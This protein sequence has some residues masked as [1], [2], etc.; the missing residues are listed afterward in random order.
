MRPPLSAFVIFKK[1]SQ[2]N[3]YKAI[4][5]AQ[6]RK[7]FPAERQAPDPAGIHMS[8]IKTSRAAAKLVLNPTIGRDR[9]AFRQN[10]A[11]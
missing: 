2:I 9:F 5:S 6:T 4:A 7:I 11:P 1:Y 8:K 10:A 3:S